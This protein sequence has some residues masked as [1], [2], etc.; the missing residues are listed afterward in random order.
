MTK[1]AHRA[2]AEAIVTFLR[3][4]RGAALLAQYGF[5]RPAPAK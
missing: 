1:S 2:G 3:S 4:E 5:T